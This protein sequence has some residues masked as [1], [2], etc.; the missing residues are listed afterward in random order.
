MPRPCA[1]W[2]PLD[3]S[4]FAKEL[5]M[6]DK[7]ESLKRLF[8]AI[9]R[10]FEAF[11]IILLVAMIVIVFVAVITRKLFHFMFT[12]SEEVTLLCLTWFTFMGIAI[13]FRERLHL[14]MD[15]F[16]KLSPKILKVMDRFVDS[17]TF[18][19]GLYLIVYGWDFTLMMRGSILAATGLPNVVQYVVMPITGVLTCVYS[20]LQLLGYDLRRYNKIEEEI[21]TDAK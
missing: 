4:A 21:K 20:V 11:C 12:W 15:V 18:L 5:R 19:F 17:V 14:G 10:I 13:G 3:P 1:T 2:E 7:K 8:L 6:G 9:D 16:E